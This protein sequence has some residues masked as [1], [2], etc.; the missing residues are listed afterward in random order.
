MNGQRRREGWNLMGRHARGH[1]GF[2]LV[3]LLVVIGIIALLI[4]M[5][6]P[7]LTMAR[8]AAGQAVCASNLRQWGIALTAYVQQN[9]G[10]LPRRGQG[11][12]PTATLSNY[13]DWFNEL[14]LFL[15]QK[16]YQ[17]LFTAGKTPGTGDNS[18]WIARHFR[19]WRMGRGSCLGMR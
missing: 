9:R 14:P 6:L 19:G 8:R 12:N 10:W 7:A 13:D 11:K 5:L 4:A 2:T 3:E 1:R 18:V 15:G 16:S 17:D